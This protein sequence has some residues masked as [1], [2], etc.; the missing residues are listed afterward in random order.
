MTYDPMQKITE[1]IHAKCLL[2]SI[3]YDLLLKMSLDQIAKSM[4]YFTFIFF[5]S[6]TPFQLS[7]LFY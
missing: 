7:L 3:A 1:S 2:K 6:G 5:K 4:R